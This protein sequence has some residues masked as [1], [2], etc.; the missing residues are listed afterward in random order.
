MIGTVIG[1]LGVMLTLA[2]VIGFAIDREAR[3]AAWDRV[4]TARRINAEQSTLND[5]REHELAEHAAELN[6]FAVQLGRRDE[7]LRVREQ[8]AGVVSRGLLEREYAV[9]IREEQ[10]AERENAVEL[11]ERQL[12]DQG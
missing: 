10:L 4:A 11:R 6:A 1:G 12:R 2:V 8:R 5:E 7:Q 3:A 9:H